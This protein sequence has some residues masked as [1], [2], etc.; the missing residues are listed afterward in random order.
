M[1]I[2]TCCDSLKNEENIKRWKK[3]RVTLLKE[4]RN[5][6]KEDAEKEATK[7]HEQL[8][9]YKDDSNKYHQV[10][11]ELTR[12][13]QKKKPVIVN[14]KNGNIPGTT[15]G[16]IEIIKQ[17]FQKALTPENMEKNIKE[18]N[19]IPHYKHRSQPMK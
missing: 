15:E 6:K 11:R 13:T 14:D 19:P 4:I 5:I 9:K 3:K 8:E 17:N 10:I 12:K 18:Y 1:K 16:K 2:I 7:D